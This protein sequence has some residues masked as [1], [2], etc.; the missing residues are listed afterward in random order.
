LKDLLENYYKLS[1]I[2]WKNFFE[3]DQVS[4][5]YFPSFIQTYAS[6]L[7]KEMSYKMIYEV[8]YAKGMFEKYISKTIFVNFISLNLKGLF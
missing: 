5:Y 6:L 7:A 8:F 1:I 3:K 4:K 2:F